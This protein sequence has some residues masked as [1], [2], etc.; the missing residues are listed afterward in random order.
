MLYE[1]PQAHQVARCFRFDPGAMLLA[2]HTAYPQP[3]HDLYHSDEWR[4]E[5]AYFREK[6]V[7]DFGF[8]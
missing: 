3:H 6:W 2:V 5:K 8:D 4:G 1:T 7:F